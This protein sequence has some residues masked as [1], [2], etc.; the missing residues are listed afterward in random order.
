MVLGKEVII[1]IGQAMDI[2]IS[3]YKSVL[4]NGTVGYLLLS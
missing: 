3:F 1:S 2:P 4:L